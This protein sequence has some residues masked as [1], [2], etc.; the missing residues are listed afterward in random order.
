MFVTQ[1]KGSELD[2][3]HS[4][5]SIWFDKNELIKTID[6]YGRRPISGESDLFTFLASWLG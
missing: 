1:L 4:C 6:T 5:H 2:C 3:C